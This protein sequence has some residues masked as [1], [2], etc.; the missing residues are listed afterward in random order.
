MKPYKEIEDSENSFIRT[1]SD[2]LDNQELVWHRDHEDRIV[3]VLC[4]DGGWKIQ[5]DNMLPEVLKENIFIK[6][7]EFHR[8]IKGDGE[9]KL[10]VLKLK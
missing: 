6:K 8:L 7:G 9:L 5:I 4:N 1:F 2:D 10:R 3:E